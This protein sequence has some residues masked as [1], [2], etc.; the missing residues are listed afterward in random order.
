MTIPVS[1]IADA[2]AWRRDIHA[3]PETAYKEFRTS[4]MIARLL[5]SFGLAVQ[6][7]IGGTGVVGTLTNGQGPTIGLRADIDALP[8]LELGAPEYRSKIQGSMHACGH[9][10]HTAILLGAAR[11]LSENRG[12]HGTIH[13]IFQPAE[14]GFAGAKAMIEDGLFRDFP[15]EGVYSLHNWP[16]LPAGH[17]GVSEGAMMASLDTFDIVLTG[18]GCHAAMPETGTDTILVAT[19]LIS[20]L[21]RIVSRKITPLANAVVSVTQIHAGDAYNVIPEEVT[22]R[23]TVRCLQEDVRIA[24]QNHIQALVTLIEVANGVKCELDYQVGYPVTMNHPAEAANV[25]KA[26]ISVLGESKIMWNMAPSMASEDFAFMLENCKGAY[27][28]LGAK[29]EERE[30]THFP[31]HSP[32]YDFND[33]IIETGIRFWKTLIDNL[34]SK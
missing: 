17:V 16:G 27:F 21:N 23:G 11:L 19:D 3:H 18:K 34:L 12:F 20:A 5:E 33:D 22:I 28:W 6:T 10:G 9:D 24:V 15:M 26:A 31:L 32:Y 1:L 13:F 14:E 25:R 29:V 4:E 2:V 30:S 7:G 8:I